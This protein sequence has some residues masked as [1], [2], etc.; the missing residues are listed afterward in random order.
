MIGKKRHGALIRRIEQLEQELRE[1]KYRHERLLEHLDCDKR[2]MGE[3]GPKR[4]RTKAETFS[5]IIKSKFRFP[6]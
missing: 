2:R 6:A 5:D 3:S 1:Q 4:S